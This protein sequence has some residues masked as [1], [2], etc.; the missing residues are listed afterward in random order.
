MSGQELLVGIN[1]KNPTRFKSLRML[2]LIL[3]LGDGLKEP[4]SDYICRPI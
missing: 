4:N 2:T 3:E 1:A